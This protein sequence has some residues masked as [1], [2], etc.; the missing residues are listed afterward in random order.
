MLPA[1]ARAN[2]E[3]S[4]HLPNSAVKIGSGI[5]EVIDERETFWRCH[6]GVLGS[7]PADR[8]NQQSSNSMG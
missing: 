2:P 1:G 4:F 3:H 6:S 5:N 7:Q 8:G